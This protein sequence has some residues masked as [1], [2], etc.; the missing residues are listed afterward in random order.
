MKRRMFVC[1]L[2]RFAATKTLWRGSEVLSGKHKCLRNQQQTKRVDEKRN[3]G[4]RRCFHCAPPAVCPLRPPLCCCARCDIPPV[5]TSLKCL[6]VVRRAEPLG[7]V[8]WKEWIRFSQE[9][10]EVTR[11]HSCVSDGSSEFILFHFILLKGEVEC[12]LQAWGGRGGGGEGGRALYD[13]RCLQCGRNFHP[14]AVNFSHFLLSVWADLRRALRSDPVYFLSLLP[15]L[16]V[17]ATDPSQSR[18]GPGA[19]G[20]WLEEVEGGGW[21]PL[22]GNTTPPA[23]RHRRNFSCSLCLSSAECLLSAGALSTLQIVKILHFI[24]YTYIFTAYM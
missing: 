12:M 16:K 13:H 11:C 3:H 19:H 17:T 5:G 23:R 6:G 21:R 4:A 20:R 15:R 24:G 18:A 2:H 7:E 14:A 22:G 10:R 1:D 8:D 9:P